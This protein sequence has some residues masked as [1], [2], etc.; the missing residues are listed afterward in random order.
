MSVFHGSKDQ[1]LRTL[2]LALMYL[3]HAFL[4]SGWLITS[5]NSQ[6]NDAELCRYLAISDVEDPYPETYVFSS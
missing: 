4:L 3:F 1:G 6:I 2:L 5:I